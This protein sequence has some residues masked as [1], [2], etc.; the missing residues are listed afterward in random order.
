M[1]EGARLRMRRP[2]RGGGRAG[3]LV[4]DVTSP[5]ALKGVGTGA[6]LVLRGGIEAG[7]GG[8]GEVPGVRG[9][10]SGAGPE[11]GKAGPRCP[12]RAGGRGPA[13]GWLRRLAVDGTGFHW[14]SEGNAGWELWPE[15]CPEQKETYR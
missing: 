10:S 14:V 13:V 11:P 1:A 6:I 5:C 15:S 8:P 3:G 7:W 12:G 9:P 2:W 4:G